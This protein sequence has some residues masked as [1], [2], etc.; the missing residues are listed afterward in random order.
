MKTPFVG[1]EAQLKDLVAMLT[2]ESCCGAV[3]VTLT[4]RLFA[5]LAEERAKKERT[6]R[7]RNSIIGYPMWSPEQ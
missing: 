4:G 1:V 3:T 6:K 5:L 2:W 7:I